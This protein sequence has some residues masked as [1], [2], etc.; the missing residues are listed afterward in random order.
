MSDL[1]SGGSDP[2]F[3]GDTTIDPSQNYLEVLVGDGKKFKTPEDLARG[4]AEA[5]AMIARLIAEKR[6]LEAEVNS[7]KRVEEL[8]D[9]LGSRLTPPSPTSVDTSPREPDA[10]KQPVDVKKLLDEALTEREKEQRRAQNTD[11]VKR[12]LTEKLGPGYASIVKQQADSLGVGTEFLSNLAAEQPKAFLK[13]LGLDG[14]PRAPDAP[15]TPPPSQVQT[16]FKPTGDQKTFSH[17]EKLRKENP[18]DY[19]SAKTQS[20]MHQDAMRLGAD[21]YK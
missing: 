6:E 11:F 13:L 20:Q 7:R 2:L 18:R 10:D 15:F 19:W 17:Y 3:P 1:F 16:G 9:Q 12:E 8:V 21:F 14:A 4:K 5:D